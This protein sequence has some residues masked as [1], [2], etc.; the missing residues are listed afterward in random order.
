MEERFGVWRGKDG[1]PAKAGHL[2]NQQERDS[3]IKPGVRGR[4][5]LVARTFDRR[6]QI[7]A[8]VSIPDSKHEVSQ[9]MKGVP[10][11]LNEVI[12]VVRWVSTRLLS[13]SVPLNPGFHHL[14]SA[15]GI[16]V[17]SSRSAGCLP[18]MEASLGSRRVQVCSTTSSP[19]QLTVLVLYTA[20]ACY[21]EELGQ[22]K[23]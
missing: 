14:H 11:Q 22:K 19:C 23:R 1:Q 5:G 17:R 16:Q 18:T 10:R 21:P 12:A 20:G 13:D 6:L 4:A 2:K 15:V 8:C 7:K 3:L 9:W